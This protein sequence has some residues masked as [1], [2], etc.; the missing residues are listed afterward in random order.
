RILRGRA[1]TGKSHV[2]GKV[3]SIAEAA[4]LNVIGLAPTH[5]ARTELAA[6]GYANNDTVKGMLFK[7][8]NGM[9]EVPKGSLIVLDEAGMVGNDDYQELLRV[10]AANKCNIILAGDERQLS[11]VQRGGMFEVF[12]R[13][14]GSALIAN[15]QRQNAQWGRDVAMAMSRG[16]IRSGVKI[17]HEQ[18]KIIEHEDKQSSMQGLIEDWSKSDKRV[19]DKLIIAISNKDVAALNHGVRQYLK[20]SGKLTGDEIRVGSHYYQK[21]DRILITET[22]KDLGLTNGDHAQL[23]EATADKFVIDKSR[24]KVQ[25]LIEFSP[26][27]YG[28]FKHGYATTVFKAQ[29]ASIS[30][31]YVYHAG[32][33]WIRNSYVALSRCIDEMKLYVNKESTKSIDQLVRQLGNNTYD[34]SSLIYQTKED[35]AAKE[36]KA[37]GDAANESSKG[38]LGSIWKGFDK[39][40]EIIGSGVVK[41]ADKNIELGEYYKYDKP[42]I[43]QHIVEEVLAE[44]YEEVAA[45]EGYQEQKV[46]VGAFA[47]ARI[48]GNSG[49]DRLFNGSNTGVNKSIAE[50]K[51]INVSNTKVA[52]TPKEKFYANRDRLKQN[53]IN[54]QQRKDEWN[55][56][57]ERLRSEV[58]Y[59]VEDIARDLL[60]PENKRLSQKNSL[61]WGEHGKL[62]MHIRGERAGI[63]CDFSS[64]KGGD[65]FDLVQ[66]IRKSDFKAAVEYLEAAVGFK[67]TT[68]PNLKLVYD[69]NNS[70]IMLKALKQREEEARE[71]K[72]KQEQ[73]IKLYDRSKGIGDKSIAY[74]YLKNVRGID[75][76][77]GK[78]IRTAGIYVREQADIETDG[79][80]NIK[81][82]TT[83]DK[84]KYYPALIAFARNKEGEITGGQQILLDKNSAKKADLAVVKKSFGKIGASFV[85]LSEEQGKNSRIKNKCD[86]ITIIAEG[87]ETAL[88]VKQALA[89][90]QVEYPDKTTKGMNILCS[91]GISN[92]RNYQPM[93]GEKI[94]IAADNDGENNITSK[95]IATAKEELEQRGASVEVV[96]PSKEGDF[97]DVLKIDSEQE[98]RNC[99]A[100]AL[101]YHRAK[102]VEEFIANQAESKRYKL[103][104]IEKA[105]LELA[106]KYNIPQD[107]EEIV[108]DAYRRGHL[109]GKLELEAL[110]KNISFAEK[111]YENNHELISLGDKYHRSD[112]D[113][114]IAGTIGKSELEFSENCIRDVLDQFT[115]Q[116]KNAKSIEAVLKVVASEQEYLG[117]I[118]KQDHLKDSKMFDE[119]KE[120]IGS[121]VVNEFE[122]Q[123]RANVKQG[124]LSQDQIQEIIGRNDTRKAIEILAT[125]AQSNRDMNLKF[126]I[127]DDIKFIEK[128]E[129]VDRDHLVGQ[130]KDMDR[131]QKSEFMSSYLVKAIDKHIV[132]HV[133][134][135]EQ[136]RQKANNFNELF[137]AREKEYDLY[138]KFGEEHVLAFAKYGSV[139]RDYKLFEYTRELKHIDFKEFRERIDHLL[140]HGAITNERVHNDFKTYGCI[141]QLHKDYKI[142]EQHFKEA[143]E[144]KQ[145]EEQQKM[146]ASEHDSNQQKK[147]QLHLKIDML[148][149]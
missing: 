1:G 141:G 11:S 109:H 74:R 116:K 43:K 19:E 128:L 120:S 100:R 71:N 21:G 70:D 32:Y 121:G 85:H 105:D 49:K 148:S 26:K 44:V 92:I 91:L 140:T 27:D 136:E 147:L 68:S 97:N 59:K 134:E 139:K 149:K 125:C 67:K 41:W 143:Q 36:A 84:G 82:N 124:I 76:R 90:E 80:H 117:K 31:V 77:L 25:E 16:E 7:H 114:I 37:Q 35:I 15:I 98:I 133:E 108:V 79:I 58:R 123:L 66:D 102:T 119:L 65:I 106:R 33:G 45:K 142:H 24:G 129:A 93:Q 3:A 55:R 101:R 30:D 138:S 75:C 110:R 42:E 146:Q 145:I 51:V 23:V 107:K 50:S 115:S 131:N 118:A 87:L 135:I 103:D 47:A 10:V 38:I 96:M 57:Q 86:R 53:E 89:R 8:Y 126:A 95:T 56:D 13:E 6:R 46:A 18:G 2:L 52:L 29:G 113:R 5:K 144:Q 132:P 14:Y 81:A 127:G 88:S 112:K 34:G 73:V 62:A 122:K 130:L 104:D 78:D 9:F 40:A 64:G 4:G 99:F 60:G 94:I 61:R 20:L 111:Y 69:H 54:R 137:V 48:G 72:Q 28:G 63:W 12:D 22:N 39:V 83:G 17:L